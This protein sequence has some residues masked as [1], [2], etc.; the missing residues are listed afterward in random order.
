MRGLAQLL[1]HQ[2]LDTVMIYTE[3]TLQELTARMERVDVAD[4]PRQA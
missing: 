4:G 3:P 1:G 2:S